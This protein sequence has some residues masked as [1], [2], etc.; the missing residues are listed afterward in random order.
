MIIVKKPEI[1]IEED[2]AIIFSIFL[3]DGKE[4]RLWYKLPASF[5][6]YLVTENVDAFLVGLLFLG[7]K[8]GNNIKLESPVSARLYYTLNHYLIPA[9]CLANPKFQKI[10][11]FAEE[12]NDKDLNTGK[13]AGTGLSCGVDSFATYY[14]H[15]NEKGAYEIKYFTFFNVGSH[16]DLGGDKA[17][18]IFKERLKSVKEFSIKTGKKVIAIDSNL[19]EILGLNFQQTHTIRSFSCILN[20]QKLF[21]NY[22]YASTYRFDYFNLGIKDSSYYDILNV[23]MLSTES[24]NFFSSVANLTRIEK[25]ALISNYKDTYR[26]LDVCTNPNE[27]AQNCSICDKCL[28]TELTL[29]L[30]GKLNLYDKVFDI[31]KYY[32]H[33]SKFI[34]KVLATKEE[35][36]FNKDLWNLLKKKNQIHFIHQIECL[37]FKYKSQKKDFK[38]FI[39][40]QLKRY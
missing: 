31:K 22:Y 3:I 17:R 38:K 23:G 25:T 7:L 4:D 36:V 16:G 13:I 8:T 28:R 2:S 20:L 12:L 6:N 21:K 14:D 27:N 24:T 1:Q 37:N 5:K 40:K 33:K 10:S 15:I 18:K 9:L 32:I 29:E 39:K 26:H 35:N 30:L 11:I 34:G 19:S